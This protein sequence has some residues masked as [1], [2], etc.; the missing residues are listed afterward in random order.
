MR[1]CPRAVSSAP[2]S[3][4]LLALKI[5]KLNN[6]N[7][8]PNKTPKQVIREITTNLTGKAS[9]H[10]QGAKNLRLEPPVVIMSRG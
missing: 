6:N 5:K 3:L 4:S 1:G 2:A 10:G 7:K 8:N 9:L